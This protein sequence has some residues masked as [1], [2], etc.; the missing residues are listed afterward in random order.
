MRASDR[1]SDSEIRNGEVAF[2]FFFAGVFRF[3]FMLFL[4]WWYR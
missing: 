4:A 3:R 2:F 1:D